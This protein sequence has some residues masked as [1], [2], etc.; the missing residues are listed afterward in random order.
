MVFREPIGCLRNGIGM[1]DVG[2]PGSSRGIELRC[3]AN[4]VSP[5]LSSF[6]SAPRPVSEPPEGVDGGCWPARTVQCG[7]SA[8]EGY[9]ELI[10]STAN[11]ADV[12]KRRCGLGGRERR[13]VGRFQT[14]EERTRGPWRSPERTAV[15]STILATEFSEDGRWTPRRVSDCFL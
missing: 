5:L 3:L 7:D 14:S 11:D 1:L 4:E 9:F 2:R 6:G 8:S 15:R 13:D 12:T 10:G